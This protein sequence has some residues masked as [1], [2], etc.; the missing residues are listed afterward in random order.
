MASLAVDI[1]LAAIPSFLSMIATS[2]LVW[3]RWR[4]LGKEVS[5]FVVVAL[6]SSW[7][8]HWSL[9]LAFAQ[10]GFGLAFHLGFCR[11][12]GFTWYAVEDPE[13]CVRRSKEMVGY[14]D[15]PGEP[16]ASS[17]RLHGVRLPENVAMQCESD[18]PCIE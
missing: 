6:R 8:G 1:T 4:L 3:P 14:V 17:G 10:Q 13:R 11:R 2:M 15:A 5:C 7:I 12:R 9:L 18:K 16:A